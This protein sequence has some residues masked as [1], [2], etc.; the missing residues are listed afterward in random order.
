M[1]SMRK[2]L[3]I[4]SLLL[5]VGGIDLIITAVVLMNTPGEAPEVL[6]LAVMF[7]TALFALLLAVQGIGA[8]NRPTRAAK[9]LP[10]ALIG[11]LVNLSDVVLAIQG[12][13]ALVAAVVNAI[14]VICYV[15]A[16]RAVSK[17]ALK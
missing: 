15:Y 8:A 2:A 11:L 1:S 5:I 13:T 14:L 16:A 12:N 10:I 9:V 6:A 17:E 4:F 7:L 3:K